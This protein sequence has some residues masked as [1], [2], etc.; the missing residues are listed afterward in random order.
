MFYKTLGLDK[1]AT[2]DQIKK[3]YRKLAMQHHPDKNPD[4]ETAEAKF[5]EITEAYEV[6]SDPEKKKH[7]DTYGT[8][9]KQPS[10]GFEDMFGNMFGGG[11]GQ[12]HKKGTNV[13]VTF[14]VTLDDILKGK[15]QT[16]KIRRDKTC[17]TCKGDGGFKPRTCTACNGQGHTTM[18]VNTIFGP[19]IQ[20][21]ECAICKGGGH[22]NTEKC[23]AKGCIVGYVSSEENVP[24]DLPKGIMD[25]MGFEIRGMGNEIKDGIDGDLIVVISEVNDT[26]FIREGI[27]LRYFL[28]ITVTE[29]ILGTEKNIK[30]LDGIIKI[31]ITKGTPNGKIL[32][33]QGKGLPH[34]NNPAKVGN[35]IVEVNVKIPTVLTD[36]EEE[37]LME[38]SNQPNFE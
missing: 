28:D 19:Q 18:R 32:R 5:K 3:K 13:Q 27:N 1:N 8:M 4:D 2:P 16:I 17:G 6:L 20:Q 14:E 9:D 33:V 15:K 25:G 36:K 22:I 26:E 29:A 24:L 30:T 12:R 10:G 35:L 7:Y 21:M 34:I 37:L 31:A 38:L 23:T 11:F